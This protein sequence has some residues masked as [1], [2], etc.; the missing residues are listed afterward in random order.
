MF[1][2]TTAY[3]LIMGGMS[4]LG[5]HPAV[6][7][8]VAGYVTLVGI[9]QAV[10]FGGRKPRRASMLVGATIHTLPM[11]MALLIVPQ[12]IRP[13]AILTGLGSAVVNGA[14]LGY[15]AGVLVAGVFLVADILRRRS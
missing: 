5:A 8:T 2:V 9:C 11:V 10:L 4:A 7:A 3:A 15:L 6:T 14:L 13:L 1:V 12:P